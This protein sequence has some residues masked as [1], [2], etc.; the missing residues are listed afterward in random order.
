MTNSAPANRSSEELEIRAAVETWGRAKWPGSRVVHE[1][2]TGSCRIDMAFIQSDHIAG[3]E[4]KSSRD[5]LARLP[6][7]SNTYLGFLPEVWLVM[8]PKWA[9]VDKPGLSWNIGRAICEAGSVAEGAPSRFGRIETPARRNPALTVP[10]L[11]LLWRAELGAVAARF[12]IRTTARDTIADIT[13]LLARALTGDQIVS[14]VCE[15]L[16]ARDA[17]PKTP[18][19]DPPITTGSAAPRVGSDLFRVVTL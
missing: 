10:M 6:V 4:I 15:Q 13:A 5:R 8:A 7:Q 12:G 19:S 14:G 9:E 16:R 1:L 11:G 2:V 3:V 18:R 17:F